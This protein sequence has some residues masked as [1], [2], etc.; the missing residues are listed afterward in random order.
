MA[1][2]ARSLPSSEF[3]ARLSSLES[4]LTGG[5][6]GG[7]GMESRIS[8]LEA[9]MA[10]VVDDVREIKEDIKDLRS[11][12]FW[13]FIMTWGGLIA[14]ALGLAGLMAKGFGWL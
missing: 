10:H 1:N 7:G 6:H 9:H 3:G 12:G 5:G 11:K 2:E 14:V 13:M 8:S 4:R